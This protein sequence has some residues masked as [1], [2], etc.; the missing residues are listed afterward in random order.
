[1]THRWSLR[2]GAGAVVLSAALLAAACSGDTIFGPPD[3]AACTRGTIAPGDSVSGELTATSCQTFSDMNYENIW[4]ESWTLEA[5]AHTAYVVRVNH[6]PNADSVDNWSGDLYA[7]QRNAKGDVEWATGWWGN[8]GTS[9]GNGGENEEL[10]L[11]TTTAHTISLRVQV[12]DTADVGAYT[13]TVESCPDR[14]LTAGDSLTGVDLAATGCLSL[15]YGGPRPVRFGFFSFPADS[16]HTYQLT[17]TRTAGNGTLFAHLSG[18][19]LDIG[20]YISDCTWS[21]YFE[22]DSSFT[23]NT[24]SDM[25]DAIY[26]PGTE[27]LMVGVDA[28]SSATVTTGLTSAAITAPPFRPAGRPF[29]LRHR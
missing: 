23:L 14:A 27:T 19:D 2:W 18:P 26:Y 8:F 10:Y 17:G 9:N 11:A 22:G 7:Y 5:Q 13:L 21:Y 3:G 24:A 29:G 16:L 15:G 4:F 1:M 25:Y 12:S 20:C 28:D 6:V